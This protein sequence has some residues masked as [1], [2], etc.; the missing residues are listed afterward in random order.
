MLLY[1]VVVKCRRILFRDLSSNKRAYYVH[2]IYI[3]IHPFVY[4]VRC[5]NGLAENNTYAFYSILYRFCRSIN[6]LSKTS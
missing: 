3:L 5:K 6:M 2:I 4:S 1:Y